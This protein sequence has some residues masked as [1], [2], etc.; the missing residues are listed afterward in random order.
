MKI[1]YISSIFQKK[2]SFATGIHSKRLYILIALLLCT[3]VFVI[4]RNYGY[5]IGYY[6]DRGKSETIANL[7]PLQYRV[8]FHSATEPAFSNAYWDHKE[9]GI[10][11]DIVD[12]VALF[13]SLDKYDSGTGWPT[14]SKPITPMSVTERPG[15]TIWMERIEVV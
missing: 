2:K 6:L 1:P 13:S 3:I 11:V 7:S 9:P 12:G 5:P 4:Y 15:N 10:Y 8:A 14:F